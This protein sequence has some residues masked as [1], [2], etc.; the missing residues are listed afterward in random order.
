MAPKVDDQRA[1][2]SSA[3]DDIY[4]SLRR[5]ED[6]DRGGYGPG[7]TQLPKADI[8]PTENV[9]R[10]IATM[11]DHRKEI[12]AIDERHR[13]ELRKLTERCATELAEAKRE[14]RENEKEAQRYRSEAETL[15][16]DAKFSDI[17]QQNLLSATTTANGATALATTLATTAETLRK[18]Q[19][20]R[21]LATAQAIRAVEQNQATGGGANAQRLEGRQGN[22]FALQVSIAIASLVI[23]GAVF[24]GLSQNRPSPTPVQVT[25]VAP[26]PTPSR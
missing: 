12:R 6:R 20:T 14:N 23:A 9:K 10:D 1:V 5:I 17:S 18:D 15:R 2:S 13:E 19:E 4:A 26:T 8:D 11:E 21:S 16:V 22:Q 3:L 7:V 25:V 24:L